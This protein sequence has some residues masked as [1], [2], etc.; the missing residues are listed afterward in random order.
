MGEFHAA[1]Y[2]PIRKALLHRQDDTQLL[3]DLCFGSFAIV[4]SGEEKIVI[5]S[6]TNEYTEEHFHAFF[7]DFEKILTA[8]CE[9]ILVLDVHLLRLPPKLW[10]VMQTIHFLQHNRD[11]LRQRVKWSMLLL[12]D[13]IPLMES[14]LDMI[15]YIVPPQK[16]FFKLMYGDFTQCNDDGRALAP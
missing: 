12:P 16:P 3:R 14:V 13:D 5:V 8:P 10:Y 15:F 9:F 7:Q 4:S 11:K 6:F 2:D 1:A